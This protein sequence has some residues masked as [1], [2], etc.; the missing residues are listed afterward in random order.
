MR[1]AASLCMTTSFKCLKKQKKAQKHSNTDL[2]FDDRVKC[3]NFE[4]LGQPLW[5]VLNGSCA[6]RSAVTTATNCQE[7][8]ATNGFTQET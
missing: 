2:D 4:A 3:Q 7:Q 1:T 8:M 5:I 6:R